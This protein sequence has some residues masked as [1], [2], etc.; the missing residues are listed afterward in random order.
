MLDMNVVKP[1]MVPIKGYV[2]SFIQASEG[3]FPLLLIFQS[4]NQSIGAGEMRVLLDP[5]AIF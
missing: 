4:C 5:A 1:M 3:N 2:D